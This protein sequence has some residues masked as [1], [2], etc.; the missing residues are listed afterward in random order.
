VTNPLIAHFRWHILATVADG[1][2]TV[3]LCDNQTKQHLDSR[4]VIDDLDAERFAQEWAVK[5]GIPIV[6]IEMEFI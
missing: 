5:V 3:Y 4:A 6:D 2:A 1:C